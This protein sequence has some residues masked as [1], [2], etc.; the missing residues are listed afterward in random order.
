MIL[1][2]LTALLLTIASPALTVVAKNLRKAQVRK[3]LGRRRPPNTSGRN[4]LI[5]FTAAVVAFGAFTLLRYWGEVA[6]NQ[7]LLIYGVWLFLF[8]VAGMFVQVLITNYR[9]GHPL[10]AVTA[11]QLIFPILLSPIVFYIIW[12]T[13]GASPHGYFAIYCAFL[14]GYFWESTVSKV[15]PPAGGAGGEAD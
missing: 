12:L 13:A 15:N 5:V 1:V 10:L 3:T 11:T 8:M 7:D 14:N 9:D 4:V 2:A 6:R